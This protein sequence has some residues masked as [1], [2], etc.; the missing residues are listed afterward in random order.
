MKKPEPKRLQHPFISYIGTYIG[1]S[2]D[3]ALLPKPSKPP[4][5]STEQTTTFLLLC[6]SSSCAIYCL[7]SFP[8]HLFSLIYTMKALYKPW[9][10]AA[11]SLAHRGALPGLRAA[12]V[13]AK[14]TPTC[15]QPVL[16]GAS[17]LVST[18]NDGHR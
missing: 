17:R 14:H 3:P 2:Q 6:F 1:D 13:P 11:G 8:H 16:M 5:C 10:V 9:Q 18:P 12:R 7:K 15:T 4:P